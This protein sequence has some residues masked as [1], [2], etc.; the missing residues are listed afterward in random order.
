MVRNVPIA[1]RKD[2]VCL[3]FYI[4][5]TITHKNKILAASH[6]T[7]HSVQIYSE[8]QKHPKRSHKCITYHAIGR[9]VT[10]RAH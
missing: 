4:N 7:S 2:Y 10:E 1:I 5:L 8:S 9:S 6:P 3:S